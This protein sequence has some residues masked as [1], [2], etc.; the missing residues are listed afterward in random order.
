MD[1]NEFWYNQT[2]HVSI[3]SNNKMQVTRYYSLRGN[4]RAYSGAIDVFYD[5]EQD[6][7]KAIKEGCRYIQANK[8]NLQPLYG[9]DYYLGEIKTKAALR[10]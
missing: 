3:L 10:N 2:V 6:F 4:L 8:A 9:M 1:N 7:D 5:G